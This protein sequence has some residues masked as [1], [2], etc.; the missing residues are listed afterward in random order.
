MIQIFCIFFNLLDAD[1]GS[2][3]QMITYVRNAL[4]GE[5]I[6]WFETLD[7]F[8]VDILLATSH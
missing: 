7:Q 1:D 4:R 5:I 3:D 8:G 2:D 6:Q